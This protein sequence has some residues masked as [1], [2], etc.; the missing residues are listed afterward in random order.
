MAKWLS[1]VALRQRMVCGE[2]FGHAQERDG[3]ERKE[4]RNGII[5][6]AGEFR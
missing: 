1:G 6:E 5:K 2:S 4:T 3:K